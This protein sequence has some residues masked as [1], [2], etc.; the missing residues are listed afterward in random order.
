M[1][2]IYKILFIL[3]LLPVFS[4]CNDTDD[5][6]AIFTGKT[7]K[8]TMI[9]KDGENKMFNFWGGNTD[10]R[11]KSFEKLNLKGTFTVKFEGLVEGDVIQGKTSGKTITSNLEGTWSANAKNNGFNATV[12]GNDDTDT[13][14]RNF[15]EGLNNAASYQ[16]D[17]NNLY[18]IYKNQLGSFRMFFRAV[19]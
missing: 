6:A 14:A 4:G 7:W 1:R 17:E 9:A 13:L 18:L 10:A 2:V 5:V 3:M 8:L 19:K 12:N 15:L 11:E 16:G